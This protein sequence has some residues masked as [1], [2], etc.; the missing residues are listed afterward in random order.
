LYSINEYIVYGK[1]GVSQIIDIRKENFEGLEEQTYYVLKPVYSE[2]S[3]IYAPVDRNLNKLRKVLT[4]EEIYEIIGALPEEKT[5]WIANDHSR[6]ERYL[7]ILKEGSHIELARLL[8][9]LYE[10]NKELTSTG[11]KLHVSDERI[12]KEAERILFEEFAFVLKIEP[13][14]VLPFITEKIEI[15]TKQKSSFIETTAQNT[16]PD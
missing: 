6:K 1:A 12:M 7:K 13:E 10:K 2:K 11:K 4:V 3:I 8:K 5:I 14:E 9:T 16:P 15:L